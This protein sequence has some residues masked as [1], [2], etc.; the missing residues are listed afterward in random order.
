AL[1]AGRASPD[2]TRYAPID[3]PLARLSQAELDA[4]LP[5]GAVVDDIYPLSPMQ[6]GLLFHTLL[7]PGSGVYVEQLVGTFHTAFDVATFAAAWNAV[8][9]HHPVLR[10]A[11]LWDGVPEPHQVVHRAAELPWQMHDWRAHTADEQRQRLAEL[12]ERDRAAGFDLSRPPLMRVVVMQ[13][14]DRVYQFVWTHHHL[15]LDGWSIGIVLRDLFAA[16]QQLAAGQPVALRPAPAYR[17]Y[18]AWLARQDLAHAERWWRGQLAGFREP[19]PLPEQRAGTTRTDHVATREAYRTLPAATTAALQAFARAHQLTLNTV[20]QAAWALVLGRHA[21]T[22]DVVFGATVSG[23]PAEVAGVEDMVGLFIN[24]LPVRV[25]LARDAALVPWLQALQAQQAELRD[26]EYSPLHRVQDWSELP[27]GAALFDSV[28]VFENYPI[29]ASVAASA[30]G[31]DIRDVRIEERLTFPLTITVVPDAQLLVRASYVPSRFDGE[32]IARVLRQLEVVLDHMVARPAQRL[33]EISLLGDAEHAERAHW[34]A[35]AA[36]VDEPPLAVWFAR[37]AA[38]TPDAVAVVEHGAPGSA[39]CFGELD[40]RAN[41][42]AHHLRALGVGPDMVVGLCLAR[43]PHLLVGILGV[44]KAGA[45]YLP[46]DPSY[47]AERLGF[48]IQDAAVSVLVSS[49]AIADELPSYGEHVVCLDGDAA[50]LAAHPDTAPA[51]T[52]DGDHLAYVIY[53]SGSTGRPKGAMITQRG[54]VNYLAWS[55]RAY[56]IADG[57]GSLVH[58]SVAFDL[59]V[60]SLLAPLVVGKPAVLVPEALGVEGLGQALAAHTGLSLLKLTPSHLRLLEQQLPPDLVAGHAGALVIGGE[61]LPADALRF[62][63][64]HAP[65]T[66][67]FNEYGPTETVVGCCVH[68]AT[69]ADLADGV[70]PIGRPIAN[71]DLFV[72]DADLN[73]VPVGAIGELYIGGAQLGRGYLRRPDLTA[74]RF[75]PHP[76]ALHPGQRLYRTGDLARYRPDG[77]LDFLGRIDTQVKLRGFRI[78]LGEI[79]VVLAQHPRVRDAVAVVHQDPGG[80]RRLVAYVVSDADDAALDDAALT[81]IRDFLRDRLPAY[82]V[83]ATMVALDALPLTSH[84][85]VDRR[86]L[87]APGSD[88]PPL[89]LPFA[90]PTSAIEHQLAAIWAELLHLERVGIHDN[91][92][93]LGG[94][95]IISIQATS[96]ARQAGLHLTPKHLFDHPTIAE[97]ASRVGVAPAPTAEQG[98]VVGDAP[99]TPIQ[100]WFFAHDEALADRELHHFNQSVALDAGDPNHE[101]DPPALERALRALV[102]HHDALRLRFERDGGRWRQR[103]AAGEDA[104][105]LRVVDL[106]ALPGDEQAA[107]LEQAA[108]EIHASLDLSTGPLLRAAVFLRGP[109][110]PARVLITIHHLAVDGVSWRILLEDLETLYRGLRGGQPAAPPLPAKTTSYRTWAEQLARLAHGDALLDELPAWLAA[111]RQDRSALPVDLPGP[112][113]V[114]SVQTVSVALTPDETRALLT[115]LPAACRAHID[116]ILLAALADALAPWIDAP[117]LSVDLEGHGRHPL[118][119]AL[120]D[121]D[122]S[123]TVGW[124]TAI[125]PVQIDLA[126]AASLGDALRASRRALRQVPHRGLGYGVLRYLATDPRAAAL[127][128]LPAPQLLF[129]YLGQLDAAGTA[130]ELRLVPHTLGRE[131]SAAGTRR[132]VLAINSVVLGGQLQVFWSFSAQLHHRDTIQRLA[133]AYLAS[134]RALIAG[135]ASPDL[136]RYAPIDFPLARLSQAELDAALPPG[137]VVD[138]VYPL[139]P[140]QQGFLFHALLEPQA[141]LYLEQAHW[142]FRTPIDLAR[143]R[144]AWEAAVQ[145]HPV[146]RTSFVWQGLREPVQVVHARAELPWEE[147]DWRGLTAEE[148]EPRLAE[149]LERDRAA[150]FDLAR[151]P[152]MRLTVVRTVGD[153]VLVVWSHHHIVLDGWSVSALIKELFATYAAAAGGPSA[154]PGPSV[155]FR[156]YI[157]WLAQRDAWITE[158]RWREA[159]AGISEP[160]PLPGDLG[161]HRGRRDGVSRRD[162]RV[163]ASSAP[164][165]AFA[166]AHQL[167]LNTVIQGAWAILLGRHSGAADVVFGGTVAGRPTDLPGVESMLGLFINTLPVRVPLPPD[168]PVVDWLAALQAQQLLLRELAHTPLVTIQGFCDVPRGTPLFESIVAFENYPVDAAMREAAKLQIADYKLEERAGSPI[169]L[170][171]EVDREVRLLLGTD[172]DRIDPDIAGR[173]LPQLEAIVLELIEPGRRVGDITGLPASERTT[174]LDVWT[175]TDEVLTTE[176]CAHH[177]VEQIAA[178]SPEAIAVQM[179]DVAL[180]YRDLDRRANQLAH[181][182]RELGVGPEVRVG[183]YLHHSP[184][185]VSTILAI[186]K[187]GGAYVPLDP[188]YPAERLAFVI[189]DAALPIIVTDSVLADDCPSQGEHLLCLDEEAAAIDAQPPSS[190][191]VTVGGQNLAYMIYTSGSTGRPKGTLLVHEGLCN[192]ALAA[193][194]HTFGPDT[195]GPDIRVLQFAAIGFDASIVEIFAT[196]VAG[197][198]LCLASRDAMAPGTPL[199]DLLAREAITTVTLTP[200]VLAQLD[201]AALPALRTVVSAGEACTPDIVRRW[202]DGRR[203]INAYGPTEVTVCATL[204]TDAIDPDQITIGR[205][206]ANTQTYVLDGHLSPVPIGAVGELCVAGPG[207]ARGYHDRAAQTAE[208]FVPHPFSRVPGARLYRTGDLV[209]YLRDGR[210]QYVGRIDSQVKLRGF[211]IELGEIEAVLREQPD[212]ADVAVVVRDDGGHRRL[213]AYL[214]ARPQGSDGGDGRTAELDLAGLRDQL[215]RTLPEHMVPAAFVPHPFSRVPGARLYR[216]GDLVRYLRDGRL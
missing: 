69:P 107:A 189:R 36:A 15:V 16:Y 115:E 97:L 176:R 170:A 57:S 65:A 88:R 134:L 172:P 67:L 28:V 147:L 74:E 59:T 116:E 155:P 165:Q 42:L 40:R 198:C 135:R 179:G 149:L 203:L 161:R 164:L 213:V 31:H 90:A 200:S 3:F 142:R 195:R 145:R 117:A 171:V 212:V 127:R 109:G 185:L 105:L 120:A 6:Q 94:D 70:V 210:L 206:W 162:A 186:L 143:F 39:L 23:R 193:A 21:G 27:R 48:M 41:Q 153:E 159:L 63:H 191:A 126:P 192:T 182:L 44:L 188:S 64:T 53:T 157:A 180:S 9:A 184:E 119:D 19:T 216:T 211:R 140:M 33:G 58:S 71:T 46:L 100:H 207:L 146:L 181:T 106:S 204:T 10:T 197:G 84:G 60:T 81:E 139:S 4:A 102:A 133:D 144:R 92:F 49:S 141:G 183:V 91:F 178:R 190:P 104:D 78:E 45:A 199:L 148:Q 96:R 173:L 79:E 24:T 37:Q 121:L 13:R 214:V 2:L 82:M 174:L 1:I 83:P 50:A 14:A 128:E 129:N 30:Q 93:E 7:E 163:L 175:A 66:R 187:A 156:N 123:R 101:I 114:A 47:P 103:F 194:A 108:T 8:I 5:P 80:D 152:L 167:T 215:R 85:K 113:T 54:L 98:P 168:A 75:V 73:P 110:R 17:D 34:N 160:T 72:L 132:H 205:A 77:G 122:L 12:L 131:S 136:T 99:L 51:V 86:A 177:L 56:R 124:F 38:R 32:A 209:R 68:E 138:D 87:P 202:G 118:G 137:A 130:A 52:V 20:M 89:A 150:G 11:V 151:A 154:A 201:A 43:S 26:F 111:Q 18:I 166:R 55:T 95:S 208:K 169:S 158:P 35:T 125:Y 76:F 112:N 25:R 29:D 62:W 22:D 196:L 61:A